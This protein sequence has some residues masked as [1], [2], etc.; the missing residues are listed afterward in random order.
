MFIILLNGMFFIIPIIIGLILIRKLRN[1]STLFVI[2]CVIFLYFIEYKIIYEILDILYARNIITIKI[3][4]ARSI[5]GMHFFWLIFIFIPFWIY[6]IINLRE[7]FGIKS[8]DFL[9]E[10]ILDTT[11]IEE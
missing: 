5:I 6:S 3:A 10:N 11:D 9:L 8:N 4:Q 2:N 1:R 7:V